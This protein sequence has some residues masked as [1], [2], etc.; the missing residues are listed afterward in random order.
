MLLNTS[1]KI[2]AALY[3]GTL[4]TVLNV[5]EVS[6]RIA[7]SSDI[8]K[9]IKESKTFAKNKGEECI[10]LEADISGNKKK[11]DIENVDVGVLGCGKALICLEDESSSTGAR[12][13]DFVEADGWDDCSEEMWNVWMMIGGAGSCE[14]LCQ[15]PTP[16]RGTQWLSTTVNDLQSPIERRVS[17]RPLDFGSGIVNKTFPLDNLDHYLHSCLGSWGTT[18]SIVGII[19]VLPDDSPQAYGQL[20]RQDSRYADIANL[21]GSLIN[22]LV[23]LL[24]GLTFVGT[25]KIC[26]CVL[27]ILPAHARR[28]AQ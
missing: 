18:S 27:L 19:A 17:I 16:L 24:L 10:K 7:D 12:C 3:V 6:A 20:V 21:P 9:N 13:V 15:T 4:A 14:N 28:L 1:F 8:R 11:K 25:S 5:R 22:T 2:Y 23:F 26:P